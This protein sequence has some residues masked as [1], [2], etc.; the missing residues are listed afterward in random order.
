MTVDAIL[1]TFVKQ[2]LERHEDL[3][4]VAASLYARHNRDG[5][6]P[7]RNEL[8]SLLDDFVKYGKTLLLVLDAL[9]E[10]RVDDRPILLRL[11][12]SLNVRIFI[13]SRPLE[14]L[15]QKFSDLTVFDIAAQPSDI[16]LHIEQCLL[17]C[18]DLTALLKGTD[19]KERIVEAVYRKSNGM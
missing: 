6:S 7:R 16:Q 3:L 1:Q 12:A 14:T 4:P 11:L 9:D 8:V 17:E 13:T 2:I 19:A 5:T 15:Q 10:L 18:P